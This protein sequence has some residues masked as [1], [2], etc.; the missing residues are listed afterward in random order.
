MKSYEE[1]AQDVFKRRDEY[2]REKRRRRKTVG[3]GACVMA[4]LCV[5]VLAAAGIWQYGTADSNPADGAPS[6][7]ARTMAAGDGGGSDGTGALADS[8]DSNDI[9]QG[10]NDGDQTGSAESLSAVGTEGLSA[11]SSGN[12]PVSYDSLQLPP[13]Q[14]K[15]DILVQFK[16]GLANADVLPFDE[17]MLSDCCAILEGEITDMYLKNYSYDTYDDKF[18]S[19]EI[20]HNQASSVVYELTVSKVWYGDQSLSGTSVLIED[21]VYLMDSCF[22]LKTGRSYVIP[23]QDAG[24]TRQVWR[25]AGGDLTKDSR[26]AILYPYHPQIEATL[27]GSYIVSTDWK[28]LCPED[29][30]AIDIST[31]PGGEVGSYTDTYVEYHPENQAGPD[32]LITTEWRTILVSQNDAVFYYDKMKLVESSEFFIQLNRLIERLP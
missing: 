9:P 30:P 17:D 32:G 29:A 3:R 20:Y 31:E 24:E 15:P 12:L 11:A 13:G 1:V 16:D 10:I 2:L 4:G 25:Y 18:G 6:E 28:S 5:I 26:Y 7:I 27:D 8:G 14:I 21:D 19:T 22:S 23:I